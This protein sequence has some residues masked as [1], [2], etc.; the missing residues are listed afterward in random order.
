MVPITHL[1]LPKHLLVRYIVSIPSQQE[2]LKTKSWRLWDL[3][4]IW[5]IHGH[6]R[7]SS[8]FFFLSTCHSLL[9]PFLKSEQNIRLDG[10]ANDE[11]LQISF[12][13]FLLNI[14][15]RIFL[16]NNNTIMAFL[17]YFFW[18]QRPTLFTSLWKL[19]DIRSYH[20]H[21]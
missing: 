17:S 20:K 12:L 3:P 10:L 13:E 5:G 9:S 11:S 8:V 6:W 1:Q 18:K 19:Q 14:L 15:I 7:I 16:Y 4:N 21:V 2:D